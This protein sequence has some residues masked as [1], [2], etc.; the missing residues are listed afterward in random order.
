MRAGRESV[1]S[2]QCHGPVTYSAIAF[3]ELIVGT[4]LTST[5]SLGCRACCKV[6]WPPIGRIYERILLM[7]QAAW[8][9][10]RA[11]RHH[12]LVSWRFLDKAVLL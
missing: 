11:A 6:G 5:G 12:N 2:G 9:A 4:A 8:L 7:E 3:F 10:R 1:T